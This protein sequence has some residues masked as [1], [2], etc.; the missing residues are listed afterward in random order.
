MIGPRPEEIEAQRFFEALG[1]SVTYIAT[2]PTQ[3]PDLQVDGDTLGYLVEVKRRTD[4]EPFDL[5]L[6]HLGDGEQARPIGV[7]PNLIRVFDNAYHQLRQL[8]SGHTRLW[9]VWVAL[10]VHAGTEIGI[11]TVAGTLYGVKQAIMPAE[12]HDRASSIDCYYARPGV[13]ERRP[14]L[15]AVIVSVPEGFCAFANEL[16][17][18]SGDV[19]TARFAQRLAERRALVIPSHR[20]ADGDCMLA[21]PALDRRNE[22]AVVDDLR[23]RYGRSVFCLAEPDH[24]AAVAHVR[25]RSSA[26]T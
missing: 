14:D 12:H 5:A 8:D 1:L 22:A 19:V 7:D 18:R 21:D 10:D 2:A 11:E 3:T 23:R 24:Y 26:R 16:N 25:P 13:F 4:T 17:P 20:E 15:D 6:R 9:I